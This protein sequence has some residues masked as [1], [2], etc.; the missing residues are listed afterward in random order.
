MNSE[1]GFEK[2]TAKVPLAEMHKYSTSLGSLTGGRATYTMH[3][4]EYQQVPA[5]IQEQLIKDFQ[6]QKEEEE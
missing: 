3:F 2:I 1:K 6:A 4:S 5:E